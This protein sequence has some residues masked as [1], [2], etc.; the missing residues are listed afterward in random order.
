MLVGNIAN[1]KLVND[2]ITINGSEVA[3]GGSLTTPDTI[4]TSG[5]GIV[6][7]N[8]QISV[9]VSDFMS[10]GSENRLLTSNSSNTISANSGLTYNGSELSIIGDIMPAKDNTYSLGS[11]SNRFKDIFVN[12]SNSLHLG[13]CHLTADG[14]SLKI[15]GSNDELAPVRAKEMHIGS[16]TDRILFKRGNHGRLV[17]SQLDSNGI[18]SDNNVEFEDVSGSLTNAQLAGSIAN[19]KLANS[20][21]SFGGVS[22]ALGGSDATP[23]FDLTDATNYS[24]SSL[25]GT[26]TNAQLAGSIA[27]DKLAGSIAN[28]KLTNNSITIADSSIELGGNIT[29]DTIAGQISNGTITNGQLEGNIASSKLA[30]SIPNGKLL[31][32]SV[33]FGGVSVSLGGNNDTPAFDLRDATNYPTSSL[34]GTITNA[35]LAGSIANDKLLNNSITINGTSVSLGGSLTTPDTNTQLTNEQV[36]D[37]VGDMFSSNTES[38]I[39]ATYQDSDGTIDLSVNTLNQ[40]TSGNAATATLAS[41]VTVSNTTSNTFLPLVIHSGSNTLSDNGSLTY[42]PTSGDLM[43]PGHIY[44]PGVIT[45]MKVVD[46]PSV[47][48]F[49]ITTTYKEIDQ[50]LRM[51]YTPT[52]STLSLYLTLHRVRP[53]YRILSYEI[54]DWNAG[55]AHSGHTNKEF[56]YS[57]TGQHEVKLKHTMFNL[58]VN[59]EYYFTFRIKSNSNY[60]YIHPMNTGPIHFWIVEH[61]SG[62]ANSGYGASLDS[63]DTSS[64]GGKGGGSG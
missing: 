46:P 38:G 44:G 57:Q 36:Q 14:F 43:I 15:S 18:E 37:I 48:N 54:Y 11:A 17:I 7:D 12:G 31:N 60:G 45:Y 61:E 3:L 62:S 42:N 1:N 59:Q 13:G 2:S 58:T 20:T 10:N 19:G 9:N 21:V 40:D 33:S 55:S 50:D 56:M 30:G 22:L 34:T 26:I 5:S 24:T 35:Q 49:L 39:T 27:N 6:I 4:Y 47:S 64:G 29:A 52:R 32:S 16:G 63:G 23:A 28:D 51:K 8:T 41:K 25:T 53:N